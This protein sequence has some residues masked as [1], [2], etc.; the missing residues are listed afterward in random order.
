MI[1]TQ[2]LVGMC[3]KGTE[4]FR[5]IAMARINYAKTYNQVPSEKI[6]IFKNYL[7]YNFTVSYGRC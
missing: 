1:N 3:K 4:F 6:G 2:L 7:H 5:L